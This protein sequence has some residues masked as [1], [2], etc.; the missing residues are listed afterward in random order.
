MRHR[1]RPRIFGFGGFLL[2][3]KAGGNSDFQTVIR[4]F[5]KQMVTDNTLPFHPSSDPFNSPENQAHLK[6]IYA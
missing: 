6:K 5:L 3:G 2:D 4:I 1:F